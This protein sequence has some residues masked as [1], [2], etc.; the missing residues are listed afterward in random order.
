MTNQ[1]GFTLIEILLALA[2]IAIAL[3]ALLRASSQSIVFTQRIKDKTTNHWVA[4]Q[5]ISSIKLGLD[6]SDN[7]YHTT[8]L[9]GKTWYWQA[10]LSSTP[11]KHM[12]QITIHVSSTPLHEADYS[13]IA[14]RYKYE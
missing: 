6:S 12:E 13:L 4:M 3:T 9:L 7:L 11:I 5:A 2:I 1:R 10:T 14:Y 8:T